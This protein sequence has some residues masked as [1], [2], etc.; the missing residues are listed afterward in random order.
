ME[1]DLRRRVLPAEE[2]WKWFG[3]FLPRLNTDGYLSL[4]KPALVTDRSD[5]KLVHLDGLNLSR[6]WRM[7]GIAGRLAADDPSR[8]LPIESAQA[9]LRATLPEVTIDH[10]QGEHWLATFAIYALSAEAR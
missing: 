8:Q 3:R 5:P 6:A 4:L 10:Y 2:F 7:S 9:H 1:A